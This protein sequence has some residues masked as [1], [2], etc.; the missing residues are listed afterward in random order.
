MRLEHINLVVKDL[1]VALN[2]YKAAFPHWRVRVSG[3][4]DWYGKERT[5][6]HFGDDYNYLS[7]NDN[8]AGEGR[9][10]EGHSPGLAH[11]AFETNDI[12]G[13]VKRMVDN[14]FHPRIIGPDNAYR[15][16][17]YFIDPDGNEIEFIEY[18]SDLPEHRNNND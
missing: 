2:F 12:E 1:D 15:K 3:E 9:D 11:F 8:G 17:V 18:M 10:L 6:L 14:N 13:L 7:L 4:G 5:W 16:N